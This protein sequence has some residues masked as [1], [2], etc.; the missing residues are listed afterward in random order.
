MTTS[1]PKQEE[2]RDSP[3]SPDSPDS[4]DSTDSPDSPVSTD[5]PDSTASPD[6][7]A[8][9]FTVSIVSDLIW[10][11]FKINCL[12]VAATSALSLPSH[13]NVDRGPVFILCWFKNWECGKCWAGDVL[14]DLILSIIS[15][16]WFNISF[17]FYHSSH[18]VHF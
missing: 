8:G 6:S 1:S 9:W 14:L 10:G 17:T 2:I 11:Q 5:S 4:T 13:T 3:E 15:S 7:P 18:F 16:L 12:S